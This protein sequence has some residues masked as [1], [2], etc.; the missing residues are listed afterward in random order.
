MRR[1]V[2]HSRVDVRAAGPADLPV[3]LSLFRE[4]EPA[5]SAL[6]RRGR[7]LV[8]PR[9][10]EATTA[11]FCCALADPARRVALAE[12]DGTPVGFGV[13]ALT[14]T[15]PL[16]DAPCVRAD[17]LVVAR[18]ARR[19]GVGKALMTAALEFAEEHDTTVL[20]VSVRHT[21]RDANRYFARLGFVP[22]ATRRVA[23]ASTVRR[24]L[25][26]PRPEPAGALALRRRPRELRARQRAS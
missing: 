3:L 13:F 8:G 25:G 5:A 16:V 2:A 12:L 23:P 11:G 22:S 7:A 21:D 6:L 20:S 26:V 1:S 15:G 14:P 4:L 19:R 17:P 24:A 9:D 10:D 18:R